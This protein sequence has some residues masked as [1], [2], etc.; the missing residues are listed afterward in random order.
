MSRPPAS[1]SAST[2]ADLFPNGRSLFYEGDSPDEF[3]ADLAAT[4]GLDPRTDHRW[5]EVVDG[6]TVSEPFLSY[7][8]H[9]PAHLIDVIYGNPAYPLGS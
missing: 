7:Q 6:T 8:F 2:W 9:C 5:W 3:A 4:Y 1:A